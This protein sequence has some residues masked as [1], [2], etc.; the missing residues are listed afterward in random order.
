MHNDVYVYYFR[1]FIAYLN[2]ICLIFHLMGGILDKRLRQLNNGRTHFLFDPVFVQQIFLQHNHD[3]NA[4]FAAN[5]REKEIRYVTGRQK[6]NEI[7]FYLNKIPIKCFSSNEYNYVSLS[8]EFQS[9][10]NKWRNRIKKKYHI[11]KQT[12]RRW[13]RLSNK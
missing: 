8:Y 4:C 12:A 3:R 11:T 6:F 10:F 5:L 9:Q 13:Q 7:V 2:G 1:K